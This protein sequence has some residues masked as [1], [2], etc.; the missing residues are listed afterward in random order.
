MKKRILGL[1]ISSS[2]IGWCILE[3]NDKTKKVKFVKCSYIKPLKSGTILERLKD[4]QNKIKSILETFKPDEIGIEEITKFMPRLSSA[5]TIITL[6]VF[7]RAV[8]LTCIDY[9][10]K[11][12]QMFNVMSLRHGLKL[13]AELPMKKDMPALVEKYL[14]INFPIEYKRNGKIKDETYDMADACIVATYYA[15]KLSGRLESIKQTRQLL[16]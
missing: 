9:L 15:F 10:D 7:N 11:S 14:N 3:Y 13:T 1:D 5:Q 4:T 8:G 6:A 16:K 2:T 12:P